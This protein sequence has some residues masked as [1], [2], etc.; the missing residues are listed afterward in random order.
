MV[1]S[2]LG[3]CKMIF[4]Q[5]AEMTQERDDFKM[6]LNQFPEGI[7]IAGSPDM[8]NQSDEN[9]GKAYKPH[10]LRSDPT[11]G[12]HSVLFMNNEI[13]DALSSSKKIAINAPCF[14]SLRD[15]EPG[16]PHVNDSP[17]KDE[18]L[19]LNN[20][21]NQGWVGKRLFEF[22]N[23]EV[24]QNASFDSIEEA[25]SQDSATQKIT[26]EIEIQPRRFYRQDCLLVAIRNVSGAVKAQGMEI[27]SKTQ[28]QLR[29]L[30]QQELLNTLSSIV[31]ISTLLLDAF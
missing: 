5:R 8:G 20:I 3:N 15:Q 4:A 25:D 27:K 16:A 17:E 21:L 24:I 22:S 31:N 23:V 9:G 2:I 12:D 18:A 30:M 7:L 10:S 11:I 14:S 19:S 13:R 29:T 28:T 1:S 6:I 26:V